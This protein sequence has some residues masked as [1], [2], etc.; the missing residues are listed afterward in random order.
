MRKL[1]IQ[2]D[3]LKFEAVGNLSEKG[4]SFANSQEYK[5][6]VMLQKKPLLSLCF[7]NVGR[8]VLENEIQT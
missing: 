2:L 6:Q 1:E 7:E 4:V 8:L 5:R 3:C